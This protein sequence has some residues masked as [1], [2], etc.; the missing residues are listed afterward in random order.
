MSRYE[1]TFEVESKSDAYAVRLLAEAA[2]DTLR[3]ELRDSLGEDTASDEALQQF[4]AIRE[5]TGR[6]STGSLTVIYEQREDSF[7]S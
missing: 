7:D 5:A 2:Y 4:A 1:A 6:Q 3:E